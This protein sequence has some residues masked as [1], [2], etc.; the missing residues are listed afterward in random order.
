MTTTEKE[1]EMSNGPQCPEAKDGL[2]TAEIPTM[3]T[4]WR[5]LITQLKQ[6]AIS[7]VARISEEQESTIT[8]YFKFLEDKGVIDA[9]SRYMSDHTNH[10]IIDREEFL[11]K[12]FKQIFPERF[13]YDNIEELVALKRQCVNGKAKELPSPNHDLFHWTSDAGLIGLIRDN[14][15]KSSQLVTK[16]GIG[17]SKFEHHLGMDGVF[18]CCGGPYDCAAGSEATNIVIFDGAL[19]YRPKTI[20][21]SSE[22]NIGRIDGIIKCELEEYFGSE[23]ERI[24]PE[25]KLIKYVLAFALTLLS[26]R[27]IV[28]PEDCVDAADKHWAENEVI[29][30]AQNPQLPK[31]ILV[32]DEPEYFYEEAMEKHP[33]FAEKVPIVT[34]DSATEAL[35]SIGITIDADDR[36]YLPKYFV[37][38]VNSG[39]INIDDWK[40]KEEEIS[41]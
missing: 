4:R 9:I 29:L 14:G 2:G 27:S 10:D 30:E 16:R 6:Q 17:T 3:D 13:I 15:S 12:L 25:E 35:A 18:T 38:S 8:A 39:A 11:L 19:T 23:D 20:C 34:M 7:E 5:I 1:E 24:K 36:M 22:V 33:E 28:L 41:V 31:M 32:E 40:Y 21:T 37:E 26:T